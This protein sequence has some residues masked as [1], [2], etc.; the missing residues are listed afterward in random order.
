MYEADFIGIAGGT[1]AGKSTLC[2]ALVDKYPEKIG[3]VQLDDYFKS[4]AQVPKLEEHTNWDHPDALYLDKLANDLTELSQGKSVVINTK[5]ERFNPDYKKT[6]KRIPVEFQPKPT[7]LMS[8]TRL[9]GSAVY[10]SSIPSMKKGFYFLCINSLP[11]RQRSMRR[12]SLTFLISQKNKL[13]R[14]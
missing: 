10:I 11:S 13:S 6:D 9:D 5:N 7:G 8:T 12:M 2:T 3:L 1:G 14:G 4:S